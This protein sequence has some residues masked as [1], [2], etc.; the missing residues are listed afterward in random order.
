MR[1]FFL[2]A[3]PAAL[4][5]AP[6][7]A[8]E[9]PSPESPRIT[10]PVFGDDPCPRSSGD[11]IIVC[12]RLPEGERYRLPKRFRGRKAAESAASQSWASRATSLETASRAGRPNSCSPVGSNGFTGCYSQLLRQWSEERRQA[13]AEASDIP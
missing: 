4:L 10:I 1:L 8:L 11:E 6:A 5:A 3:L 2:A 7:A 13:K 9:A 12:A